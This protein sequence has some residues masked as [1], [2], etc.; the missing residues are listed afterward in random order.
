MCIGNVGFYCECVVFGDV[1][2]DVFVVV[3]VV[4]YDDC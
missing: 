4:W 2:V 1:G 3:I